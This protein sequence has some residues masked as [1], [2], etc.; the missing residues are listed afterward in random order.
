M[1]VQVPTMKRNRQDLTRGP[2]LSGIITYTVPIILTSVLQLLFNAADLMVVGRFRGSLTVGAVGAT[3][4]LTRLLINFFIGLSVGAGVSVAHA[5]GA[6]QEEKLQRIIHTAVFVALAG[7]I[8]LTVVG[9]SCAN[10]FLRTDAYDEKSS[11]YCC[12]KSQENG[13]AGR[14]QRYSHEDG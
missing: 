2:L 5:I 6:K 14:T 8:L 9:A 10:V 3:G 7:G 11:L 1:I 4:S 12:Y 13:R